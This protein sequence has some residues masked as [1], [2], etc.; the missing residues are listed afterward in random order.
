MD[1]RSV[2]S[3]MAPRRRD[4]P[5]GHPECQDPDLGIQRGRTCVLRTYIVR[6]YYA[7]CA[8]FSCAASIRPRGVSRFDFALF[9]TCN[10]PRYNAF[11]YSD[12]DQLVILTEHVFDS[13][14]VPQ[15]D[16]SFSCVIR[17]EESLSK[18]YPES[19]HTISCADSSLRPWPTPRAELRKT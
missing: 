2:E 15:N 16:L 14:K 13:W 1:F 10:E 12:S 4:A 3:S 8:Y 5:K 19:L 9:S 17:L 11:D 18:G 6:P 7:A